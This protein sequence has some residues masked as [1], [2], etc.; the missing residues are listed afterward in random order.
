[1]RVSVDENDPGYVVDPSSYRVMLDGVPVSVVTADEETGECWVWDEEARSRGE[2]RAKLL[3]GHVRVQRW[4]QGEVDHP[5]GTIGFLDP[6]DGF[7]VWCAPDNPGYAQAAR[8]ATHFW[9]PH[10]KSWF[11]P[12]HRERVH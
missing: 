4:E 6:S 8:R 11:N 3:R 2:L 7:W 1:M 9:D 12:K 5:E 10:T